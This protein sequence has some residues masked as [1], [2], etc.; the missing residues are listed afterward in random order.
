MPTVVHAMPPSFGYFTNEFDTNTI[1]IT[2]YTGSGAVVIPETIN[3]LTV[4]VIGNGVTGVFLNTIT[5]VTIPDSVIAIEDEA[6]EYCSNMVSVT[7]PEGV[8]SI[9]YE[10]FYQCT[11]LPSVTIPNTVLSVGG[12]A[13]GDCYALTNLTI[14]TNVNTLGEYAF[15]YCEK[16]PSVTIPNSVTT[17]QYGAFYECEDLT[18]LTIGS[19]VS[20]IGTYAFYEC[21]DLPSLTIPSSVTYIG[22]YAFAYCYDLTNLV[23]GDSQTLPNEGTTIDDYAFYYDYYL[24]NVSIGNNVVSIGYGAFDYCYDAYMSVTIGN[25]VKTIGDYAFY[26][27]EYLTNLTIG[28]NVQTIGYEAFAYDYYLN[29]V[30]IPGSVTSIGD[31]AFYDDY[32]MTNLTINSGA[33][34]QYSFE[35]C[36]ALKTVTFGSGVTSIIGQ[37][38]FYYDTN[39]TGVYFQGDAPTADSTLFSFAGT[40]NLFGATNLTVYYYA[41][42]T[43]WGST[44]ANI[45]TME[46]APNLLQ[47]SLGPTGARAAGANWQ[48]DGGPNQNSSVTTLVDVNPGSHIVSFT[49]ISGWLT[50]SNQTITITNGESANVVGIYTP[51]NS[52]SNGL[53]LQTNGYGAIRHSAWPTPLVVGKSYTVK[54]TPDLQNV[55]AFW[56][57]GTNQP[58]SVLSLSTSY[59]FTMAS[60]LVL[61]ANFVT[62]EFSGVAG[63]YNGLFISTHGVTEKTAGMLKSLIVTKNGTYS[64]SILINGASHGISGSFN[65]AGMATNKII[66]R[67]ASQG[68]SLL[69]ELAIDANDSPSEMTGTVSGTNGSGSNAVAW[70]ANLTAYLATNSLPSAQYTMLVSPDT[71]NTPPAGSPGGDSYALITN[72]KGLVKITG[73]LADGTI[74]SESAPVSQDSYVP[75]Y[76]SL[77]ANKGLL[78]GWINLNTSSTAI[79]NLTWIHPGTTKGLYQD[80]FTNVLTSSQ[81]QISTWTNPPGNLDLLT[82]LALLNSISSTNAI[83]NIAVSTTAKGDITG[84]SVTGNIDPKTGFLKVT[85]GSG[86]GKV[87]GYGAI[88]LD[89]NGNAT[90]SGGYYLIGTNAQ[91][92][93]IEP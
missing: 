39:I 20:N 84:A 52:S 72:H 48:L 31:Y 77:Y 78:L 69:L 28:T 8:T 3:G 79:N 67:P 82:N 27:T 21:E 85:I 80:G 59:T 12:Y 23:I 55:F 60:N 1:T 15:E 93:E 24:Q 42:T 66:A 75:V 88:M 29:N 64:G 65:F 83:T 17:I 49:P 9:G 56:S 25:R 34:G 46:L 6:F 90:N 16:L 10:A 68:G 43:G 41:G 38:P 13:F 61:S 89:P 92:L 26:Y 81:I 11:N 71:N 76:S 35:S 86:S 22:Y 73:A 14:G 36:S 57:G 19:N 87:T 44:F 53:V 50:P 5:N 54:A 70:T 63:T 51:T 4:T 47:I 45:P 62:N 58:Y 91:A 33:I 18:N 40:T 32:N 2:N 37:E 7:I 30:T 74:L